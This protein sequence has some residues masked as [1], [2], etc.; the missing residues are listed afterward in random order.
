MQKKVH[1]RANL[2]L[3]GFMGTG[4]STI[5]R[6]VAEELKMTFVDSDHAIEKAAGMRMQTLCRTPDHRALAE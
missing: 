3:V 5:G 2:Y 6:R 1:N 4:K